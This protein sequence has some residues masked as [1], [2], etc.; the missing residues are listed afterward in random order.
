MCVV[1][2]LLKIDSDLTFGPDRP[3]HPEGLCDS[4]L[5][6]WCKIRGARRELQ[7]KSIQTEL[8]SEISQDCPLHCHCGLS[9]TGFQ[10]FWEFHSDYDSAHPF[11]R[12]KDL[13]SPSC[14]DS[15]CLLVKS[16][17]QAYPSDSALAYPC[18]T[19]I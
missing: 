5:L 6:P 3:L 19:L 8:E 2:R 15:A 7:H 1:E 17:A 10:A 16:K 18:A 12:T 9:R 13:A 11:S 4:E 14:F